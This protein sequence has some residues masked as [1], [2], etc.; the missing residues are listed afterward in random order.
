VELIPRLD[1][2]GFLVEDLARAGDLL[3]EAG[4]D[5]TDPVRLVDADG[6]WSGGTQRTTVFPQGYLEVQELTE[7]GHEH[8]LEPWADAVP[9]A[10][11]VA[12]ESADLDVDVAACAAAGRSPS[13]PQ[14]WERETAGGTARFR[15]S[16]VAAGRR[17]PLVVLVEHLTPDLIHGTGRI[18]RNGIAGLVGL[19][20]SGPGAELH[21]PHRAMAEG[22]HA[23]EWT[24]D[25]VRL[26]AVEP[27]RLVSRWPSIGWPVSA[28]DED[29]KVYDARRDLGVLLDVQRA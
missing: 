27:D 19:S 29:V 1:H 6:R 15:F 26:A 22:G 18:Q 16:S 21:A 4:F 7:R 20:V 5:L 25:R 14:E 10:V 2:V 24:V 3:E 11:V 17:T 12:W 13:V 23:G 8:P 28:E 9:A